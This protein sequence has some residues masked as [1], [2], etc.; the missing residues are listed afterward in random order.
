MK[1]TY[2]WGLLVACSG[3]S[4]NSP[5]TGGTLG[6]THD[7]S[8][9]H[10]TTGAGMAQKADPALAARLAYSNPG[11]MWMPQQMALPGH[12]EQ[13]KAM[14][15]ALD[16]KTL[17]DPLAEPLAAVISLGGCTASFVSDDGLIVTNHHCVQQALQTASS[18]DDNIVEN[19]FL[20]KT[21]AEERSAGPTQ[22]VYVAQAFRDVTAEMRDGLEKIKDPVARKL[23]SE[24]RYKKLVAECEKDRPWL[25]CDLKSYF[26]AGQYVLIENLDIK[27]VRLVYAPHRSIGNY[28]GEIDNWAWPRHTGDFS[29]Y[30]AYV[31]RDGKPAE[32]SK[33]NIPYHPKHKLRV[34]TAGLKPGDLVMITGYPGTTSRTDTAS[35]VRH[36]VEWYLPYAIA[37]YKER[38]AIAESHLKDDGETKI[39]A[40][41][42][43][44]GIQNYME[45]YTG[46]LKGLTK[47][48]LLQ[49]KEALDKKIKDWA[50]QPGNEAHKAAIEK[51]EQIIAEETRTARVD[52]DRKTA[53][54]GSTLLST[55]LSLTRWAE[56]RSKKDADRKPGYQQRD[57]TRALA[58]TKQF[59]KKYDRTLDRD[60]FR[61][62]LT[63]AAQL[64]EA[65]RPW[66]AQ[67]LDTKKGQVIDAALIDKTLDAWYG[68][69]LLEDE[70]L[71]LELLEKGTPA[72]LKASKDPFI[73]A[74]QRIWANVK[75]EEKRQDAKTGELVLVTPS[76]AL[77]MREVLGGMLSPDANGSLRITYGTVRSFKPMSKDPADSPFTVAT[78]IPAKNTGKEPFHM[79]ERVINAIKA[80]QYGKYADPAL[81][82]ELPVDFLSDLDITNG[83]SG[84]PTLN[85][86]GEL[87]GLAFDGTID[88]V[89]SDV[90]FNGETTR[91]I[92]VDA[93]YMLW[94]MDAIDGADH[95]LKEMGVEPML[96]TV[97]MDAKGGAAPHPTGVK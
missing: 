25:R 23:E 6:S 42:Q 69:Q 22:H 52:Y 93:R 63:R 2:L 80:K 45:K 14:G 36:E 4:S 82:G 16:A 94:M 13:F 89:S 15:A 70:K 49:R 5:V 78:Q 12:V 47:G 90:V 28:G 37:H 11:G 33:D 68:S 51:L 56:E 84:S 95:L 72:K 41:V 87:V 3:G 91:T 40:T 67:L 38:Y 1:S 7:T 86:K 43:K 32:Y 66:L 83:N 30:R 74:A 35:E 85:D 77:A 57:M 59:K 61:L 48:D 71:R 17:S 55:A 46:M 88:G 31:G 44:Q 92:H 97:P 53:F 34:S 79:P 19:G 73:K 75:A 62:A 9:V 50:A 39:K 54:G 76:Y 96:D 10:D 21:R 18:A 29:F 81:K 65:D 26:R 24:K 20:A 60:G 27:D 64:P 8:G 58:A